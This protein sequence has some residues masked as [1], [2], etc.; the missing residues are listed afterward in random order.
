[1]A[2]WDKWFAP[3]CVDC[4]EKIV[5]AE[6]IEV[7]GGVICSA[8]QTKRAE[9]EAKRLAEVEAR[10]AAEEEARAKLESKKTWGRDPYER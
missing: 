5:G 1:M 9:A 6:P 4:A 7:D 8:C 10:R 2:F 3:A